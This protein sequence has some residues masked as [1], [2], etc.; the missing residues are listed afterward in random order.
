MKPEINLGVTESAVLFIMFNRV[1]EA[2]RS[3]AA[4]KQARPLRLYLS[5][6][7]PRS[8]VKG[9]QGICAE[10][11]ARVESMIDW[12]CEVNTHYGT[13][14][15]GCGRFVSEAISRA[16]R[17]EERLIIVE[18]DC[19]AAPDFF[20]FCDELLAFYA[21]DERVGMIAGSQFA[22]GGW[23]K[24]GASYSFAWMG[25]IW[26]WATWRRAWQ[27]YDFEMKEWPVARKEGWLNAIFPEQG[28]RRY[29]TARFDEAGSI[30]SWDYQWT[31]ARW[32]ARQFAIVPRVN[33]VT[34][35]GFGPRATHTFTSGHPAA[36]LP[37]QKLDFPLVHPKTAGNDRQLDSTT[38]KILLSWGG[39]GG[40][41]RFH[42]WSRFNRLRRALIEK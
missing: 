20:L 23:N 32:R 35:I 3:F 6:D 9:E 19:V 12:P 30:D 1:A 24:G 4:V 37:I 25:Q 15:V 7:G 13:K 34:N 28:L 41:L 8:H 38:A 39:V 10:V 31:F 33:L 42:L 22:P 27:R 18:D 36:G 11:R 21:K 14:N 26:G 16:L 29:W 2:E 17:T 40:W 5:A